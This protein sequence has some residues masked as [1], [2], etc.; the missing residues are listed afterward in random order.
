MTAH[1]GNAHR[2][3]VRRSPRR[4]I[5]QVVDVLS[6]I[7]LFRM[8]GDEGILA[9]ARAGRTVS[10][11]RGE[12]VCCQGD[13][14][15]HLYVV[16]DGLVEV[17]FT[18]ERGDDVVLNTVDTKG[19]FGELAVLDGS[20]RS[21]SVVAMEPTTVF[22]LSR[23]AL[24][25]L[26]RKHPSLVDELLRMLA[27]LVRRL[28]EQAGDRVS[29]DLSGRLAKLLLELTAKHGKSDDLVLD[30]GLTQSDLAAMIGASRPAV[31]RALQSLIA[32]GIVAVDGH[33]IVIKDAPALRKCAGQ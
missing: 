26:I 11:R 30:R 31:N 24:L 27:Q 2:G 14:G 3:E 20:P 7:P 16:V 21:A 17:V 32:R 33:A 19:V 12:M 13:P 15:D 10:Y 4:D 23:N 9:M 25:E 29:L 22:M 5:K 18:T 1:R 6:D 8:V 28:T